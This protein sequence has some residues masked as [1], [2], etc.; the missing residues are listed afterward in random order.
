MGRSS[1]VKDH[2]SFVASLVFFL[3]LG[4]KVMLVSG[5]DSA[6][7]LEVLATSGPVSVAVGAFVSEAPAF[8]FLLLL[9]TL[10][11]LEHE[12]PTASLMQ[13]MV[14]A[15]LGSLAL[16]FTIMLY[17][18]MWLVLWTVTIYVLRRSRQRAAD[19]SSPAG[20]TDPA[21][22]MAPDRWF[23]QP[24]LMGVVLGLTLSL[25]VLIGRMWLPTE[26]LTLDSDERIVAY[27][28]E[29]EGPWLTY[30]TEEDRVVRVARVGEVEGRS[31]CYVPPLREFW[32]FR[33]LDLLATD[34]ASPRCP[35]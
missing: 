5:F 33:T 22:D 26:T 20:E 30:L 13:A 16:I 4:M 2:L 3:L 21:E 35:N 28:L 7:A 24:R 6:T 17:P 1:W 8:S 25:Q 32:T 34:D 12:Y 29:D 19:D 23:T 15:F 18:L 31:V 11:W 9:T 27:V 14:A 10:H